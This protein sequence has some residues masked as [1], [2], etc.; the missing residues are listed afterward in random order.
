MHWNCRALPSRSRHTSAPRCRQELISART[1]PCAVAAEDHRAAGDVA[2]AEV[3]RLLQLG[4]VADVDPALVED[5]AVLGLQ[6]VVG[7]EHLAV[8]REGQ[9]L[10]I[11][12]DEAAV[13][14]ARRCHFS[15]AFGSR[16]SHFLYIYT[17]SPST[18][19]VLRGLRW[20][21]IDMKRRTLQYLPDCRITRS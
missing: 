17:H 1:V 10:V 19:T 20:R 2:G 4:G 11:L 8:D 18:G 3:A 7:D 6:H 13:A 16:I 21:L 9:V 15:F 12:D 5:G 14:V